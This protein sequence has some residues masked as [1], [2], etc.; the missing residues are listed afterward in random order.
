MRRSFSVFAVFFFLFCLISN[1]RAAGL[2]DTLP[3]KVFLL[4][5]NEELM[6]AL[7]K[8]YPNLLIAVYDNNMDKAYD[9]W[10]EVL[11][12]MEDYATSINYD[13]KG[14]KLWMNIYWNMDGYIDYIGFYLKPNSRNIKINELKAFFTSYL[15]HQKIKLSASKYYYHNGSATFPTHYNLLKEKQQN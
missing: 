10:M 13:L 12:D 14:I 7:N 9:R 1:N 2:R 11:S 3:S 4:G 15:R 8:K 5:E 6:D